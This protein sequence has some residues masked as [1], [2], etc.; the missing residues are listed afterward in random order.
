M[1]GLIAAGYGCALA[2]AMIARSASIP[3]V[4]IRPL[5]GVPRWK[6]LATWMDRGA[7]RYVLPFIETLRTVGTS[8]KSGR[9]PTKGKL[10]PHKRRSAR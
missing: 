2:P 1:I 9:P 5:I 3:G 7:S 8:V 4:V 10:A 6:L